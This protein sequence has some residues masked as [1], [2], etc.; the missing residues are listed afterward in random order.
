MGRARDRIRLIADFSRWL[1][2]EGIGAIDVTAQVVDRYLKTQKRHIHPGR[3][4][5]SALQELLKVLCENGTGREQCFFEP[6]EP[7]KHAE[8]D[9]ERY[10]SQERGLSEAT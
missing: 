1:Q 9:F 4:A 6:F 3:G 8:Q 10:L 2:R 7:C 5:P